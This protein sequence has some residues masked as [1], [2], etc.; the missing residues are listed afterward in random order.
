[1]DL[2]RTL[3]KIDKI[4]KFYMRGQYDMALSLLNRSVQRG[5]FDEDEMW[6]VLDCYSRIY[7][8]SGDVGRAV[9][10]GWR[11]LQATEGQP[12]RI[13][14]WHYSDFLFMLHYLPQV[15]DAQ[16]RNYHFLY[17]QFAPLEDQCG[18]SRARHRHE[19]LRIGYLANTFCAGVIT[20]FSWQM[21]IGYDRS[22]YEVYCY[23]LE[24]PGADPTVAVIRSQVKKMRCYL[25]GQMKARIVRDIYEDEI[26]I[27]VDLNVHATGGCTAAVMCHRPAPVQVAGIGYMATSGTK[28]I[29][30]FIGDKYCDPPEADG[31]FQEKLLRLRSH[32][33]YTPPERA[34]YVRYDYE[35]G[36]HIRFATF[37]NCLKINEEVAAAWAEIL[38]RVPGS[39]LLVKNSTKKD[40]VQRDRYQMLLRAGIPAERI[41]LEGC[42]KDYLQRYTDVDIHLDTFPYVGGATTAN[43]LLMGVPVITRYGQRHGTRFGYSMLMNVGLGELAAQDTAGYIERAVAL[44]EDKELLRLLH[45]QLPHRMRQSPLM[46]PKGYMRELEGCYERIWQQWLAQPKE[47]ARFPS[48]HGALHGALEEGKDAVAEN[49]W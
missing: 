22:R 29:D 2:D 13:Q 15:T 46:D 41:I 42:T 20:A 49:R 26:D 33:C 8:K 27:L 4:K 14:Q 3:E 11:S 34:R 40:Y 19:R 31:D 25:W 16:M 10:Y 7:Y 43:S 23:S 18:H 32:F 6:V 17:D 39:T 48:F 9:S 12:F 24:E 30:Y 36:S 45:A 47:P 37:N 44:A 28:A 5:A 21:L 38:R 35:V 1:M